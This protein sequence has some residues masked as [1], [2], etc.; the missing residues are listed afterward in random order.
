MLLALSLFWCICSGTCA[1]T[2]TIIQTPGLVMVKPGG[3]VTLECIL[4]E[5]IT[6]CH[7]VTW[8]KVDPRTEAMTASG[9]SN[10]ANTHIRNGPDQNCSTT[11]TNATARDSGMHYCSAVYSSTVHTG[12]GSRVYIVADK[13]RPVNSTESTTIKILS[14]SDYDGSPVPLVCLIPELVPS[15]VRVFWLIDGRQETGLTESGWTDNSDSA[16][17]FTRN[18]IL[19]QPEEWDRGA[20]CTCVVEF[21]GQNITKTVRRQASDFGDLCYITVWMYRLLGVTAWL[22]LLILSVIVAFCSGKPR[23]KDFPQVY[24]ENGLN[25]TKTNTRELLEKVEIKLS[26]PDVHKERPVN[27]AEST[28]IKIL[29][30]SDS[31]WSPVPLVCLVPELVPSQVRVFW[32]IDGRQETGLTESGWTDNSDSATEFTRNQILVQPEEW[33]RGAECT[34]VVEFDGK[35]I[36]KTVYPENGLN[37][38]KTNARVLLEKLEI[39]LSWPDVH[40]ERPVNSTESTTIKILSSSDY[41]GSPVP[42]VCLIPELVPSQVRVFWLIDGREET[43]PTE[44][45]WTDNSDSATEFT[46]NQILVQSEKWDRGAECTCVVEFDGQNIN[47]TPLGGATTMRMQKEKRPLPFL[48]SMLSLRCLGV[49]SGSLLHFATLK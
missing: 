27:S 23:L 45:G 24:Q 41:D 36:N 4:K 13:E 48:P 31:D 21:D 18:Q 35:N 9:N 15:Q 16:T 32:L 11:I 46:R 12:N 2:T 1:P 26:W 38:T 7:S 44:S 34:C 14:S 39:K 19:V 5:L 29:S 10:N 22:L 25:S 43:G 20:E 30:P 47:K 28:T 37:S 49:S 6:N 40:K 17:E 3:T 8:L 33:D 42:L